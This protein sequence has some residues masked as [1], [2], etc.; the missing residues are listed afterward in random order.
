MLN[1][2]PLAH[3]CSIKAEVVQ[4]AKPYYFVLENVVPFLRSEQYK[5]LKEATAPGGA[6][7]G[8][9]LQDDPVL[10]SDFGA[11]QKR[12]RAVV[13]GRREGLPEVDLAV[14]P[15]A[16]RR[17]VQDAIGAA[18]TKPLISELASREVTIK[19]S[20]VTLEVPGIYETRELHVSRYYTDLSLDRFRHI[21]PGGNRFNLPFRL[22][23]PCWQKHTTGS[24]DV[25]GRLHWDRPSV[26]I[27]TESSAA[28]GAISE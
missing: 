1:G 20:N 5:E 7:E 13:I 17:T 24:G 22:Q 26:T 9:L 14:V 19:A 11:A 21:P 10:A 4:A 18:A 27:R 8:Y 16:A 6:L 2:T 23:A 28:C 12:R 15:P 3:S 25:M